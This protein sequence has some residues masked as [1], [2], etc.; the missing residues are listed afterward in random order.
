M[1]F[2]ELKQ[3]QKI[4]CMSIELGIG[5]SDLKN[6]TALVKTQYKKGGK[7]QE[8]FCMQLLHVKKYTMYN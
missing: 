1:L 7:V 6:A 4:L 2:C 8:R 5:W 3:L